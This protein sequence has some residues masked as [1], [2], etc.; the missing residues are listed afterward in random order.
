MASFGSSRF[1][2]DEVARPRWIFRRPDF[3]LVEQHRKPRSPR[4]RFKQTQFRL[5]RRPRLVS[6]NGR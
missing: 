1:N 6:E 4:P 3:D 5:Q 2:D